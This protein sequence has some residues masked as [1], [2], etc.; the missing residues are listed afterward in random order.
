MIKDSASFRDRSGYVFSW[1]EKIYRW[2]SP[3]YLPKYRRLM[4][5]GLYRA[6]VDRRLMV[7]HKEVALDGFDAEGGI[8]IQPKRIPSQQPP[9]Q[10]VCK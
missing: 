1:E 2:I 3:E 5:S 10:V 7:A 9:L 8:I 6:L 4:D